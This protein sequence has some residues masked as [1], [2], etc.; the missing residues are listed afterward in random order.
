MKY[1]AKCANVGDL[2]TGLTAPTTGSNTYDNNTTACTSANGRQPASTASGYPMANISQTTA[3]T[4]AASACSGCHLITEAE[5]MTIAQNVLSVDSNWDNGAGTHQ[6]GFGYAYSGHGDNSP[7]GALVAAADSSPYAGTGQSSPSIQKRTLT[8]TNG[9]VIWDLSGNVWEWTSGTSTIGQPGVL[10]D[11]LNWREWI[12]VT[13]AGTVPINPFPSSL[14]ISGANSWGSAQ[15]IG[16]LYSNADE[17]NLHSF[18]RG[19]YWWA[20]AG[21]LALDLNN[22]TSAKS[23]GIGLRASFR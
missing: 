7:G 4:T 1:E 11:G 21:S 20:H 5:W 19:G 3:I 22:S 2:T 12:N 10:G 17:T 18:M 15:G 8:L 23:N 6:V 16:Q 13:T 14:G 9:E